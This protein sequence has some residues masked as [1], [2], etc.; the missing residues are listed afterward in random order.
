[1]ELVRSN[2][3]SQGIKFDRAAAEA[4]LRHQVLDVNLHNVIIDSICVC[5]LFNHEIGNRQIDLVTFQEMVYSICYRLL[6]FRRLDDLSRTPAQAAYHIGLTMIVMSMFLRFDR[7]RVLDYRLVTCALSDTLDNW[8]T[9]GD[10]ELLLWL[11]TVGGIWI[12]GE[13]G[14][15]W[16]HPLIRRTSRKIG[17]E[18]WDSVLDIV[19][20]FPWLHAL[21]DVPGRELWEAVQMTG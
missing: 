20:T 19:K 6:N 1:M 3:A 16:L 7:R 2:L 8:P 13:L 17:I 9:D 18:S 10:D 12:S 5:K 11:M 14:N 15:E 4:T 21:H